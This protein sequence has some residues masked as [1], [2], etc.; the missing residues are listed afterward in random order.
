MSLMSKPALAGLLG[1]AFVTLAASSAADAQVIAEWRF[2]PGAFT[3]DSSGNGHDLTNFG[4]TPSS[5]VTAG[6]GAG[7]AAFDGGDWLQ[8]AG[9]LNLTPY[10]NIEISW[11]VRKQGD[12]VGIVYE[13]TANYN[14]TP[15]AFIG[16]LNG[17][18]AQRND[19]GYVSLRDAGGG[20][21]VEQF[22]H[23]VAAANVWESFRAEINLDAADPADVVRVFDGAGNVIGNGGA[24]GTAASFV[25]DIFAIGARAGG[26]AGVVGNID[27]MRIAVVPE[28]TAAAGLIGLGLLAVARRRR[29]R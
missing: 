6:G 28:P 29:S 20:Y 14:T 18:V 4:A 22:P 23:A 27:E 19:M 11:M 16:V 3:A 9:T 1:G 24:G 21:N 12:A 2:E 25:N 5:D 10:R 15:G 8:T 17:D 7:S 26:A 13:H